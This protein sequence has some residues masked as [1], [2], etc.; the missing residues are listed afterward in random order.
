MRMKIFSWDFAVPIS[1]N[2][3]VCVYMYIYICSLMIFLLVCIS[4]LDCLALWL[5]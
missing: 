5:K 1:G 2:M 4:G 3:C